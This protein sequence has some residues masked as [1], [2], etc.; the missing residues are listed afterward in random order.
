MKEYS[1]YV[2]FELFNEAKDFIRTMD[3]DVEIYKMCRKFNSIKPCLEADK[4][5]AYWTMASYNKYPHAL[6]T[7]YENIEDINNNFGNITSDNALEC[8]R[9]RLK[10]YYLLLK[11]FNLIGE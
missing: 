7:L 10:N 6:I 9:Y 2:S 3:E 4:F 5:T 11:E 8:L 1:E